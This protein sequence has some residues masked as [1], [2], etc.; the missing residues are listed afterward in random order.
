MSLVREDMKFI[1][2]RD[3]YKRRDVIKYAFDTLSHDERYIYKLYVYSNR[4]INESRLDRIWEF[5]NEPF[6]SFYYISSV[7]MSVYL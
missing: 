7:S 1:N 2:F 4:L 5:L 6:G 3:F